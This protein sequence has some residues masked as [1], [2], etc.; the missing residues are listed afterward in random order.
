[1]LSALFSKP[2]ERA[3][4]SANSVWGTWPG[5]SDGRTSPVS[6]STTQAMQ[7]L[8]VSGCVRLI[9]E[10]IATLPLDVYR[11]SNGVK[12]EIPTPAWLEQPTLELDTV[13]FLGQIMTSLLTNGNAYLAVT[14]VGNRIVEVTP[15]D[16]TL[17]HVTRIGVT[18]TFMV[19]GKPYKGE[20][21]HIPG[22]MLP[23]SDVGLS[24]LDYA[25]A[26]IG[27]G[28][29]A[30]SFARDQFE[31]FLNMPGVISYPNK[32]NPDQVSGVAQMWRKLRQRKGRGL[33]GV[34]ESG[35]TW[36]TT[37]ISN[38]AAQFLQTQQ[39]TAAQ[40]AA[41][42]YMVDPSD[43]GIPV[44]GTT[45]TYAN[46][47]QRN[48]RR[49]QVTFLPWIV[50]VEKALSSLLPSP[51]YVKLNVEGLLRADSQ[52]RWGIYKTASEINANAAAQGMYPVLLTSE[53][54]EWEDLNKIEEYDGAVLPVPTDSTPTEPQLNSGFTAEPTQGTPVPR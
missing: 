50:R 4:S 47:E 8:A 42:V 31:N 30:Q 26:T 2:E 29:E 35:G 24:P 12:Q 40:I 48:I 38:E 11:E 51:Q 37:A 46:L 14:R 23:G 34:L 20:M 25:R 10:S 36:Q 1:M 9:S 18:K 6:Y 41:Q 43:L 39:W 16:P 44:G 15:V 27:V 33:P 5:D 28:L 13:A 3:T 32:M 49:V 52:T 53:M 21:L 17:V 22:M 19:S 54:R 45:L 7:L